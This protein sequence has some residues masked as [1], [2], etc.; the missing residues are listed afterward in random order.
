MINKDEDI[1][2]GKLK[3][4]IFSFDFSNKGI[5]Y[6]QIEQAV[7]DIQRT[8]YSVVYKFYVNSF[9]NPLP[10][11]FN[12]MPISIDVTYENDYTCCELFVAHGYIMEIRMY[13]VNGSKLSMDNFWKGN[14]HYEKIV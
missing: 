2:F 11:S 6:D 13:N 7:V 3:E 12:G 14:A 1:E 5:F 8:D 10:N 4:F 9:C